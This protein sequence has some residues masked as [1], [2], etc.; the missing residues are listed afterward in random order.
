MSRAAR[1]GLRG[2]R[3]GD[4]GSRCGLHSFAALRLG[5]FSGQGGV[6]AEIFGGLAE[7]FIFCPQKCGRIDQYGRD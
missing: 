3:N 5:C 7:A 4:H 6:D 2:L 1:D